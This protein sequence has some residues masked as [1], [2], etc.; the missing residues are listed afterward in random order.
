MTLSQIEVWRQK[1]LRRLDR[2]PVAKTFDEKKHARECEELRCRI[3][4][5]WYAREGIERRSEATISR[6]TYKAPKPRKFKAR[7]PKATNRELAY[8]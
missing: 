6:Q 5:A 3:V 8:A 2:K 4:D 1:C 7:E